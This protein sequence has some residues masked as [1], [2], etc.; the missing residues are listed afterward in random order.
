MRGYD[1]KSTIKEITD[2]HTYVT[3]TISQEI[4]LCCNNKQVSVCSKERTG[5]ICEDSH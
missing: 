2:L 3:C 5:M 1:V 4:I